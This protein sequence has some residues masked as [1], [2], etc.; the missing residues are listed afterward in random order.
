MT[1]YQEAPLGPQESI[2]LSRHQLQALN[3]HLCHQLSALIS[4]PAKE[5]QSRGLNG[6]RW[7]ASL[8]RPLRKPGRKGDMG[9]FLRR[10]RSIQRSLVGYR[11]EPGARPTDPQGLETPH[12]PCYFRELWARE[13]SFWE[14]TELRITTV[15]SACPRS[16][17]TGLLDQHA[18]Q[19]DQ[20]R[21]CQVGGGTEPLAAGNPACPA[22][23]PGRIQQGPVQLGPVKSGTR[24]WPE[25]GIQAAGHGPQWLRRRGDQPELTGNG[26]TG[27]YRRVT[28][29]D[30]VQREEVQVR[31]TNAYG[32]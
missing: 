26:S 18:A 8:Q 7:Q 29:P 19:Q 10:A 15:V 1:A 5:N 27:G 20:R 14:S 12:F 22:T 17:M 23:G 28:S 21:A 16:L 31:R 11:M 30:T 32:V 4:T 3:C 2:R 6:P 9:L 24:V 13:F 25:G